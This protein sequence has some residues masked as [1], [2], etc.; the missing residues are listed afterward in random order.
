MSEHRS[1]VSSR[2]L[3]HVVLFAFKDTS[4]PQQIQKAEE[5]FC[6]LP[7]VID[8]IH[9]FEWGTDVSVEN[10]SRGY[11]HCFLVTFLSE[12]DRNTYLPHPAHEEFRAILEPHLEKALV[13]D[14]WARE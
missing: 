13:L 10:I 12:R 6:E 4:T 8:E 11:T 9:D 3:R 2:I 5:A 14:Y 7:K 1:G